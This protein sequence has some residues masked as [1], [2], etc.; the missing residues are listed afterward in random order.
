M[1]TDNNELIKYLET[2]MLANNQALTYSI[3]WSIGSAKQHR[4]LPL[5]NLHWN[6]I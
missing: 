3:S 1:L 5:I 2:E 4:L 6:L